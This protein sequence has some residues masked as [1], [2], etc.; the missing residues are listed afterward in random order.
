MRKDLTT[1]CCAIGHILA[2]VAIQY[3]V[4]QAVPRFGR[5]RGST[6]VK[7]S[8]HKSNGWVHNIDDRLFKR[9]YRMDKAS[10]LTLLNIIEENMTNSTKRKRG[11][12]PNGPVT[13]SYRLSMALRYFAGGDPLDIAHYHC[14]HSNEVLR[15]VWFVVDAIH[16]S[17]QMNIKFPESHQEQLRMAA[18]FTTKSS[19]DIS[20]CVGAIDGILINSYLTLIDKA[21]KLFFFSHEFFS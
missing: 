8:R 14:V 21:N 17:P 10:F 1:L 11:K 19:I 6:T 12:T 13:K 5:R 2:L 20:N 4:F 16:N 7:R 18:G 15:S 3:G 9:M